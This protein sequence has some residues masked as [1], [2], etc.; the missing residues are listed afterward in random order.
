MDKE[1]AKYTLDDFLS[2]YKKH[3]PK[4]KQNS[5][6]AY[7]QALRRIEKM[8]DKPLQT[9]KLSWLINEKKTVNKLLDNYSRNSVLST[10]TAI[11]KTLRMLDLPFDEIKDYQEYYNKLI[12]DRTEKQ[13]ETSK[14]TR[15]KEQ[16]VKWDIIKQKANEK[17]NEILTKKTHFTDFRNTMILLLFTN[18]K[19]P[20]R[21]AD[22]LNM[23]FKKGSIDDVKKLTKNFN[24]IVE[25][26]QDKYAFIFNKYKTYK[27]LGQQIFKIEDETLRKV[28]DKYYDDYYKRKIHFLVNDNGKPMN[29]SNFSQAL[30]SIT[31]ELLKNDGFS[32][33]ILR[34]SFIKYMYDNLKPDL[35]KRMEIAE[36]MGQTYKPTQQELYYRN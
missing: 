28:I 12:K 35:K 14:S 36:F 19:A 4:G 3:N 10:L 33:D 1:I 16:W 13:L 22:F 23:K 20:R 32:V 27:Y 29:Q 7:K 11:I 2:L 25:Y 8:Y 15:E 18:M 9:L 24:Y 17:A 6:T 5:F 34:H 30:K 31:K 26:Q 21:V